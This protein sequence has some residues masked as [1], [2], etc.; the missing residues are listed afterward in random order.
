MNSIATHANAA[1]DN[2]VEPIKLHSLSKGK[3]APAKKPAKKAKAP[4]KT[5]SK[6]AAQEKA[7]RSARVKDDPAPPPRSAKKPAKAAPEV[8]AILDKTDAAKKRLAARPKAEAKKAPA[9]PKAK[10][11][12][13]TYAQMAQNAG[14]STVESPVQVMWNLCDSM[15]DKKRKEVIEAAVNKGIAYY[16]ARTQYQ[17]WL[18]AFRNS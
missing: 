14:A 1:L 7:N 17:L 2:M 13:S 4:A 5:P 8:Q 16:T 6:A 3:K 12:G 10:R 18:T 11:E 15:Q 9:K